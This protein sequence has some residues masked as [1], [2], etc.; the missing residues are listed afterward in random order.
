MKPQPIWLLLVLA[1][2]QS[3]TDTAA[4]TLV[5]SIPVQGSAD[6]APTTKL[7][8]TFSEAIKQVS[9]TVSV[10][11][12]LALG[13]AVWNDAKTAVFSPSAGWQ[14]ATSYSLTIEAED[15]AGNALSGNKTIS[16]KSAVLPDTAAP[17]TPT[18]IKAT[19]GDGELSLEW[20]ANTEPDLAGYTV[21]FGLSATALDGTVNVNKPG[22]KTTISG[23]ENGKTYFFAL[24]AYDSSGNHSAK[25]AVDS[26]VPEDSTLPTLIS[27]EP[28]NGSVD[29]SLVPKLHLV[30]SEPMD[31]PSLDVGVCVRSDPPATATCTNPSAANFGTPTW[32]ENDT[33]A[34]YTPQ[35]NGFQGGATYVLMVSGK[36]K[37]G[38]ALSQSKIAFSLRAT[39][40]TNPPAVLR[41]ELNF[42]SSERSLSFSLVFSEAMDQ[43][44]VE[45]AFLSQPALG[46]AWTWSQN[47]ATCRVVSGLTQAN[48][49]LTLGSSAKDSAGNP[50]SAAYQFA[51]KVNFNPYLLSVSP[52]NGAL[53]QEPKVDIVFTFSEPMNTGSVEGALEVKAGNTLIGGDLEWSN[54]DTVLKFTPDVSY[55]GGQ[56]VTWSLGTGARER[57]PPNTIGPT[58]PLSAALSGS[59]TTVFLIGPAGH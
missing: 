55:G 46:C 1:A 51:Q 48:Y 28:P 26:I 16:F 6:I 25:S 52:R 14:A 57:Q 39:P 23:L 34:T 8:L 12:N 29:L 42:S 53:R 2:C 38:N 45:A 11:P 59:F 7:A 37:A 33:T 13:T 5:S 54:D 41:H 24:D 47:T 3:A 30:F 43:P 50:L 58:L 18:G 32:S 56:I 10:T 15:L 44:S 19:A 35:S 49:T 17:A 40:D 9:L 4:P 21:Y 36:D 31:T 27:S 22:L 20:K